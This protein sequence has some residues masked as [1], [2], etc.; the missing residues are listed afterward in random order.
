MNILKVLYIKYYKIVDKC[1][2]GAII[3][4]I[5]NLGGIICLIVLLI[6]VM[7][8]QQRSRNY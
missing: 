8:L 2:I 6:R 5:V 4:Y 1:K 3:Y 7:L